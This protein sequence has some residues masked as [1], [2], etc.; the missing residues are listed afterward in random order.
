MDVK[1]AAVVRSVPWSELGDWTSTCWC[2]C[3]YE[4]VWRSRA[5]FKSLPDLGFIGTI[6]ELPCPRCGSHTRIRKVSSDPELWDI[7]AGDVGHI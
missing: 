7:D 5:V 2:G 1:E 3:S 6:S 4:A